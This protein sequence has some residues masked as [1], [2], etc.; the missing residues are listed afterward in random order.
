MVVMRI[1]GL[2]AMRFSSKKSAS[3]RFLFCVR[4]CICVHTFFLDL[5]IPW[6][7][8]ILS[9]AKGFV[10]ISWP[11]GGKRKESFLLE[12]FWK[13][14]KIH[15]NSKLGLSLSDLDPAPHPWS[16]LLKWVVFTVRTGLQIFIPEIFTYGTY[17]SYVLYVRKT[18]IGSQNRSWFSEMR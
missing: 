11:Y 9:R 6:L 17:S 4:L 8:E 15:M 12:R 5:D 16:S 13:C 10:L 7:R 1:V 14:W 2:A 18:I 3:S